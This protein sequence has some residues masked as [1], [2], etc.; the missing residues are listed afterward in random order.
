MRFVC[1]KT[2]NTVGLELRGKAGSEDWDEMGEHGRNR[3]N[4][5]MLL[6]KLPALMGQ[7]PMQVHCP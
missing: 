2:D 4:P 7:K 3:I 1:A 5:D 6:N